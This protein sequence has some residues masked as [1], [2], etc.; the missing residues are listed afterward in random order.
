MTLRTATR[1]DLPGS[2]C[3][4]PR[5]V[6]ALALGRCFPAVS[7]LLVA[8]LLGAVLVNLGRVTPGC[9]PPGGGV[10]HVSPRRNRRPRVAVALGD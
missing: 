4:A 9:R 6:L 3:A 5:Q 7:P 1:P 10:D 8:I 2:R